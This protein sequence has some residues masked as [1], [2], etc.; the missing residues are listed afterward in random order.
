MA[1][2]KK[3][4]SAYVKLV[5]VI[6]YIIVITLFDVY[7]YGIVYQEKIKKENY[8]HPV[9]SWVFMESGQES[10]T[11]HIAVTRYRVI[12]KSLEI[13]G[14]IV[15]LY[16]CGLWAA[17]GLVIS[18]YL[19]T[20]DMLFYIVLG[21]TDFLRSLKDAWWLTNWYQTGYFILKPF[22]SVYF[23]VSGIT[24]LLTAVMSC[25]IKRPP[26]TSLFYVK[27]QA[28]IIYRLYSS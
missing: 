17:I 6:G 15:V 12:Q 22:N 1:I 19:M 20:Y 13:G 18:H 23:Y 14:I 2:G 28:I 5:I 26:P 21:Q 8:S 16:F 4:Q 9:W 11:E 25:F 27:R 10:G 24:G 3:I 7:C